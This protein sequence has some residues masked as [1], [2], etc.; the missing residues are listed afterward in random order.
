LFR[1]GRDFLHPSTPALVGPPSLLCNGYPGLSRGQNGRGVALTIHPPSSAEVEDTVE[2]YHY[3]SS[4][5]S[6]P[7]I[8]WIM[9]LP[10]FHVTVLPY[11]RIAN[12]NSLLHRKR[13]LCTLTK[14]HSFYESQHMNG[15]SH[16]IPAVIR[17]I[18]RRV[19]LD[20]GARY[21]PALVGAVSDMLCTKTWN[22]YYC[23]CSAVARARGNHIF[24]HQSS[25]FG[26]LNLNTTQPILF[27]L[28]ESAIRNSHEESKDAN[29]LGARRKM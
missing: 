22:S 17:K 14:P 15:W 20:E 4:S 2:L 5:P 29:A 8:G 21:F 16:H 1:W 27:L 13:S 26:P 19:A 25:V 18:L 3:F 24:Q 28:V 12:E 11:K 6:W 10:F 23:Y 9:P 7:V